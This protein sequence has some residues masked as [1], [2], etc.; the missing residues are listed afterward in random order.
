VRHRSPL[1]A[2]ALTAV[3]AAGCNAGP[4]QTA[5]GPSPLPSEAV[6]E[7]TE[8]PS[9]SASPSPSP[10]PT[11]VK[12][13]APT[14]DVVAVQTRL[15]ELKY[16]V[17]KIDGKAGAAQRSA[18]MAFQKVQG[19]PRTGVVD[20]ATVNALAKPALP[21]LKASSPADRIEADLT[22]QVLYVVKAG[23]IQR[24]L[25]VSSGNGK[26]YRQKN[27]R[28]A[29]ALSPV[30]WYKIERRIVGVREA[31][32]G[33]LYDP[34][35]FY[36]GWAIH[37]SNSVPA[38]EASHGCTRITRTDAKWMLT[39]TWVGMD[40]FV[41]GGR[42]VFTAGSSAPGTDNP[43][44][45]GTADE[46]TPSPSPSTASPSP[47]PSA[48]SLPPLFPTPSESPSPSPSPTPSASATP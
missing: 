24:I 6:L 26:A 17:G 7:P 45:D 3:F 42:Y 37:G 5:A 9:P 10:S 35:Y 43:T 39:N 38:K 22:K 11:T 21:V 14:Y 4:S 33:T 48:S 8:S 32:L 46:A 16:Y 27:G 19:L 28:L 40:V 12:P 20:K 29:R 36:K 13:M 1:V 23:A 47:S 34:Q 2:V 30:G 25:P 18:V 31:D 15:T 41:Y 44:G